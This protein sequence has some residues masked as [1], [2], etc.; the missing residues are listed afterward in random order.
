[1]ARAVAV[2]TD[3]TAYLPDHDVARLGIRVVRLRVD[4][5]VLQGFEGTDVTPAGIV[6]VLRGRHPVVTTSRP[7]VAQFAAIYRA[8][9]EDGAS[10]V[11][12]VH[13][14]G[15][16]SGTI[17]AARAAAAELPGFVRVVDS[18]STAMGLGFPVLAAG[19]A[20]ADGADLARVAA[21]ADEIAQRTTTLFYV[22]TLEHLRRGGRIGA[23]RALVGT[24]L[25]MKPILHVSQ[26]RIV[27]LERVRTP[28]R[29]IARLAALA[30]DAAGDAEVD[31]AV[32]HLD[33]LVRAERLTELV[34]E[35]VPHMRR[36]VVAQVGAVIG[37]HVGPGVLGV[38]VSRRSARAG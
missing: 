7:P 24:A 5:G 8:A 15:E 11:V 22:D 23:A 32:H 30:G 10:G 12:S 33:A 25:S 18:R 17:G 13:L 29:G 26:G 4:G 19:E 6:P 1:M 2:V 38:V 34:R 31:V 20:A 3:S 21:I 14:S 28:S 36:L 9:R 16:L 37:A 35:S 27:A